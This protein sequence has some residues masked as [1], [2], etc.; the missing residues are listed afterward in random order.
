MRVHCISDARSSCFHHPLH[1]EPLDALQGAFQSPGPLEGASLRCQPMA[2]SPSNTL[3]HA[4]PT[5]KALTAAVAAALLLLALGLAAAPW[6]A[7]RPA[8]LGRLT[9]PS[10]SLSSLD[11]EPGVFVTPQSRCAILHD[12]VSVDLLAAVGQRCLACV[13][14]CGRT[15]PLLLAAPALP[16]AP[17]LSITT[18]RCR[19]GGAALG[20]SALQHLCGHC[21][22]HLRPAV[23]AGR[24]AAARRGGRLPPLPERRHQPPAHSRRQRAVLRRVPLHGQLRPAWRAQQQPGCS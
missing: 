3:W 10:S 8:L 15:Q 7:R 1:L 23:P 5:A 6:R 9:H 17:L 14:A 20:H 2:A 12:S 4:R 13:A 21:W 18:L 22:K 24:L 16:A 11:Q 19:H